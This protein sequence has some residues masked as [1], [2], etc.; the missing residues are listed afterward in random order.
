M[1]ALSLYRERINARGG[2][3]RGASIKREFRTLGDK[4][5][6][7]IGHYL[8][9]IDGVD[10]EVD[11]INSDN[12]EEKTI[13]SLPGERLKGGGLVFWMDNYWLIT[14]LDANSTVYSKGKLVQCNHLLKWI[15]DGGVIHEQWCIVEDGTKYL[16][17]EYESRGFVVTRGDS[18]IGVTI[19]RNEYTVAFNR[20]NRF[21]IDDPDTPH[22]LS[23][24]LTKPLKLG[25]IFNKEGC[26]KF[27]MQEV[28]A[29]E[30]DNHELGIADY[31]KYF[32]ND[33]PTVVAQPDK[34]V[35]PIV[36]ESGKRG[37][38]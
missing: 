16:T 27:V 7:N 20:N 33:R 23:Y 35:E 8:V 19:A 11:I 29:T 18:R 14:E 15:T 13:I 10:Q 36:D 38:L 17:G 3:K 22:K 2:D 6:D 26:F 21:L 32:P 12:T 30:Y 9:Q 5:R 37:W 25:H 1:E 31:Y 28:T 24:L 34:K 4:T